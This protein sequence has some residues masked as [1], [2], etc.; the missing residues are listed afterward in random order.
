MADL[1]GAQEGDDSALSQAERNLCELPCPSIA[2][3]DGGMGPAAS[4]LASGFDLVLVSEQDLALVLETVSRA[5][6]ASMALVQLLRQSVGMSI[7]EGLLAE[8]LAYS[9]LQSGPE[10]AAWLAN[11]PASTGQNG[12][13]GQ[14]PAVLVSRQGHCLRLRLNRP[15]RC[16][17]FSVEMRD[18]LAAAL[19]L[20]A[21][22]R[23]LTEIVLDAEGPAFCAGGDLDEFG[24]LPDPATAHAVR[25]AL[26]VARLLARCG[27][28]LHVRVHGACVGAGAEL[29]A[30]ARRVTARADAYFELP[31]VGMG[32]VPGAGGTVSLARRIGR[33]KTA[34]WALSGLRLDAP[35]ALAWGLVD[36]LD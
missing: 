10:F 9:T 30:F 16:N 7:H 28:R 14:G 27:P 21:S 3:A 6:L 36:D 34:Y 12:P 2:L 17:A 23:E 1:R 25:S 33:Q 19:A 32:L 5:P 20:A 8:S 15:R 4:R 13:E 24:S 29:A 22:D 35:T 11:R 26:S 18:C 31:E